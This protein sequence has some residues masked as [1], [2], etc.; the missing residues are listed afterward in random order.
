M[1]MGQALA[2]PIGGSIADFTGSFT[3]AFLL[4]AVVAFAGMTASLL[5]RKPTPR[6]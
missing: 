1:G 4:S 5:L 2:P 6:S 3:S